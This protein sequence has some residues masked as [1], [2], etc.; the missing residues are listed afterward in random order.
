MFQKLS[1]SQ[2][3]ENLGDFSLMVYTKLEGDIDV[4]YVATGDITSHFNEN[5]E[6]WAKRGV[7]AM[8][9]KG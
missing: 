6:M 2:P 9:V 3:A 4:K 8:L 7:R 5:R 1:L